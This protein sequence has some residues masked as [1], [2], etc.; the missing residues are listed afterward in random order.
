MKNYFVLVFLICTSFLVQGQ[1]IDDDIN[2]H[3]EVP[4]YNQ[5]KVKFTSKDGWRERKITQDDFDW[6][7]PSFLEDCKEISDLMGNR[8]DFDNLEELVKI[9]NNCESYEECNYPMNK[10]LF[11]FDSAPKE[12]NN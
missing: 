9:Y 10:T 1:N 6:A 4:G 12:E 2:I 3:Q 7:V 11:D 5:I 8:M